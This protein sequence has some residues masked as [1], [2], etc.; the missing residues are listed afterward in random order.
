LTTRLATSAAIQVDPAESAPGQNV[1]LSLLDAEA[2]ARLTGELSL[3][4][5][6]LG[7]VLSESGDKMGYVYFPTNCIVSLLYVME[8]GSS[9]EISVVGNEGLVGICCR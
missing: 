8:N 5:L 9:A 2:K 7:Q 6:K 1:L 3:V 4:E